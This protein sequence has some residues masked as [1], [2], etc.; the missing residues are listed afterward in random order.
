MRSIDFLYAVSPDLISSKN[1]FMERLKDEFKKLKTPQ[2]KS[3]VGHIA[4]MGRSAI[5]RFPLKF[6]VPD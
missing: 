4:V 3:T 6:R 2:E 1:E 5:T